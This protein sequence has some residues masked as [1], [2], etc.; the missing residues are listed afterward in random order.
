MAPEGDP[1]VILRAPDTRIDQESVAMHLICPY[2]N[3]QYKTV[4]YERMQ[5]LGGNISVLWYGRLLQYYPGYKLYTFNVRK[6]TLGIRQV[7]LAMRTVETNSNRRIYLTYIGI[8]FLLCST[9]YITPKQLIVNPVQQLIIICK[10]SNKES[11]QSS[12]LIYLGL[13]RERETYAML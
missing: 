8:L 10:R 2:N 13:R 5:H 7:C 9:S 12:T 4:Q 11:T 3:S 1:C 6:R